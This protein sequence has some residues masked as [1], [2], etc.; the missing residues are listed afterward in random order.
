MHTPHHFFY[1]VKT[2]YLIYSLSFYTRL[3]YGIWMG[4]PFANFD[5]KLS[6]KQKTDI[7]SHISDVNFNRPSDHFEK[8]A[9][10]LLIR[11]ENKK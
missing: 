10:W 5:E 8:L 11:G 9:S 2:L 6:K 3:V 7:F 4:L 1:H